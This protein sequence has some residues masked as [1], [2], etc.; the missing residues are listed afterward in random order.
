M[1]EIY[2]VLE[3]EGTLELDDDQLDLKP[4]ITVLIKPG[5]I[6][7]AVGKLKLINVPVPTFDPLDE[8]FPEDGI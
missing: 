5:C 4:G 7:R 8:W 2:H 3:G 1:T 6:H